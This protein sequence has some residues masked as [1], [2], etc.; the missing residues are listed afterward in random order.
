MSN[1]IIHLKQKDLK[2]FRE[3][4]IEDQNNV[5][6]IC[7]KEIKNPVLDHQHT[8]R[9]K[10]TGLVRAVL[11]SMC[12]T[13]IARVENNCTRHGIA[14]EEL[15]NVLRN[16]AIYFDSEHLPYLHPTEIPK[17]PKLKKSS[18]NALKKLAKLEKKFPNYTGNLTQPLKKLYLKYDL[19]PE[20]Y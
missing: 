10:G 18:Y 7:K 2:E 13:F 4:L 14:Q 5:C 15:S 12:N 9:V 17:I 11:C 1:Q 3:A 8:K 16:M 6:P 20:F 19:T